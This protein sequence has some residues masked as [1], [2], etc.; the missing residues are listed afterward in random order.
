MEDS[1]HDVV[2]LGRD[3]AVNYNQ[4]TIEDPGAAHGL[5]CRAHEESRRRPPHQMLVEIELAF[6]VVIGRAGEASLYRRAE[7]GQL[8]KGGVIDE[9]QHFSCSRMEGT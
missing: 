7:Q 4:I 5:S 9:A 1:D 3:T 6:D 2:R 8:E